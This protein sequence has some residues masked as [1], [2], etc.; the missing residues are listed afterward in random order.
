MKILSLTQGDTDNLGDQAIQQVIKALFE[1]NGHQVISAQYY[2]EEKQDIVDKKE[3]YGYELT[4]KNQSTNRIRTYLKKISV[5]YELYKY[6]QRFWGSQQVK[7]NLKKYYDDIISKEQFDVVIIGGGQL[8]KHQHDFIHCMSFW[9]NKIKKPK[10]ILGV[11]CDTNLNNWEKRK[12]KIALKKCKKV[13]VRDT[14]SM[15]V[16]KDINV[17]CEIAPDIVFLFSE[18]FKQYEKHIDQKYVLGEVFAY[19]QTLGKTRE[20]YYLE[21]EKILLNTQ[22][23]K[24]EKVILGYSTYDDYLECKNFESFIKKR[25]D[26]IDIKMVN[27]DSLEALVKQIVGARVVVSGRMHVLILAKNYLKDCVVI[28]VSDKISN[29]KKMYVEQDIKLS[30]LRAKIVREILLIKNNT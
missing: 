17:E 25:H 26:D 28:E 11:G 29:F 15:Q 1:K 24:D 27:T 19:N 6:I 9:C 16:M 2:P 21:Y 20:D 7:R 3:R 5:I 12:Y 14:M 4:I 30:E 10:I 23:N 22:V 18:L 13:V 8:I